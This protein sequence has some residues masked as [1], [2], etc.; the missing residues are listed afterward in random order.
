LLG[1][2]AVERVLCILERFSSKLGFDALTSAFRFLAC[3]ADDAAAES[4]IGFAPLIAIRCA[5]MTSTWSSKPTSDSICKNTPIVCDFLSPR[6]GLAVAY[7]SGFLVHLGDLGQSLKNI[8]FIQ[9]LQL[10]ATFNNTATP[11]VLGTVEYDKRRPS[12]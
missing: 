11:S 4:R 2:N 1:R 5:C 7:Q 10:H 3:G 8:L 9:C 12:V 6:R